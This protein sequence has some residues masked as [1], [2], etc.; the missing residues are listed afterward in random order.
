MTKFGETHNFKGYDFVKKLEE[1]IEMRVDGIIY[2]TEKPNKE[3]LQQYLEQK[4]EFVE[5]DENDEQW[6]NYTLYLSDM[7]DIS[8]GVVRHDSKKLALLIQEIISQNE[9]NKIALK[10]R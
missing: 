9:E 10:K 6:E 5:I 8:R 4:S 2:N 3:I 1:F 7:L